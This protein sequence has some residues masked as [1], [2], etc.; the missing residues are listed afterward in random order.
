MAL[1]EA[2]A[3]NYVLRLYVSGMTP[4]SMR[5]IENVRKI[6]TEHLEGRYT[7]EI[8][9]I[10]QQPIFAKEGQIIAAPTLVKELPA[11]L[12]KFIGDMSSVEKLLVGLDLRKKNLAGE[13]D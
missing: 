1:N 6:C 4:K 12:R 2:G 3:G 7:L 13:V 9:D 11:P 5:A 8:I 10:Y